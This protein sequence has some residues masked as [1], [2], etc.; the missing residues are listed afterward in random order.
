[1]TFIANVDLQFRAYAAGGER[2]AA[3][4]GDRGFLV[5]W[6]N[7]VFHGV[8]VSKG[9]QPNPPCASIQDRGG[10]FRAWPRRT[11]GTSWGGSGG[12]KVHSAAARTVLAPETG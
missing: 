9:G 6:V 10:R 5:I 8:S 4:T 12:A 11:P 1:M 3:T 7:A 2:V